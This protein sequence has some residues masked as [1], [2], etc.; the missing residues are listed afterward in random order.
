MILVSGIMADQVIEL[1][2]ARLAEMRLPHVLINQLTFPQQGRLSWRYERGSI[3][4][5]LSPGGQ[6]TRLEDLTGVFARYVTWAMK[7]DPGTDE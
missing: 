1:M 5:E 2:S 4:G 7:D 3:T 6:T